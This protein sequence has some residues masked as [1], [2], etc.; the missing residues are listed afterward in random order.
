MNDPTILMLLDIL[1]FIIANVL[2]ILFS[3]IFIFRFKKYES[4]EFVLGILSVI[5]IIPLSIISYI[6]FSSDREWWSFTLLLPIIIF[7]FMELVLDY[8]L[9]SNFRKTKLVVPYL[10]FYY[11]GLFGMIGYSFLIGKMYGFITLITY[12][13][14]LGISLYGLAKKK[15]H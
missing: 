7:L 12:F 15:L 6:N 11:L 14:N 8:I 5:M 2:N 13:I 9:K 10:L 4:Y 1:V 3:A